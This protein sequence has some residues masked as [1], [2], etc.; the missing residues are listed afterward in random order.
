LDVATEPVAV[1][2]A[3]DAVGLGVLDARRVTLG[4]NAKVPAEVEGLFV[5]E[6]ELTS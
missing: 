5:G 1:G 2:L 4:L 6:A 3:A